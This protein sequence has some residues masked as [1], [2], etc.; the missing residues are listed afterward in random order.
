MGRKE[1][2]FGIVKECANEKE[3]GATVLTKFEERYQQSKKDRKKQAAE[4]VRRGPKP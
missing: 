3:F 2:L 4:T 1:L